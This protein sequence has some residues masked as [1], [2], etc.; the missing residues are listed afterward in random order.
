[1]FFR[2]ILSEFAFLYGFGWS[3]VCFTAFNVSFC[4][5]HRLCSVERKDVV[6]DEWK[7]KW[8]V[9]YFK[10]LEGLEKSK[11]CLLHIR[12][13]KNVDI[14]LHEQ[15]C[16]RFGEWTMFSLW[17]VFQILSVSFL[18]YPLSPNISPIL[19]WYIVKVLLL[20]PSS[21]SLLL[22]FGSAIF[23]ISMVVKAS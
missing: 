17:T 11:V 13:I 1:M 20:S 18:C 23:R 14:N 8:I 15:P 2:H 19:P 6:N 21:V 9:A 12:T 16:I 7:W 4:H 5:L 10:V 3:S 22:V